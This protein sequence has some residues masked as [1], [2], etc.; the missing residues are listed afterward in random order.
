MQ[1]SYGD[2]WNGASVDVSINGSAAGSWALGSGSSGVDSLET[3]N[4]DIVDSHLHL[5]HMIV[6]LHFK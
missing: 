5:V 2:G 4:G 6:K 1:D 3:L